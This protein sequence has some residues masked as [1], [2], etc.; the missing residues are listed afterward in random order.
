MPWSYLCCSSIL[1][2]SGL[3]DRVL[4]QGLPAASLLSAQPVSICPAAGSVV[5]TGLAVPVG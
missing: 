2:I 1:W 4:P 3:G 5:D